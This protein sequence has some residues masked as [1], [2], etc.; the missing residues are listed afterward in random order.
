MEQFRWSILDG[1][2]LVELFVE[3]FEILFEI[4]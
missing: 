3:N 1:R 2:S 4:L